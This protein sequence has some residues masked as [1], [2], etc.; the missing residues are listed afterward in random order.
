MASITA[1]LLSFAAIVCLY[2]VMGGN[3]LRLVPG[4]G[5]QK[6]ALSPVPSGFSPPWFCHGIDCPPYRVL[7]SNSSAY[8]IRHYPAVDYATTVVD[9]MDY[10]KGSSTGEEEEEEEEER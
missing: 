5:E 2:G 1:L 3:A 10:E 8:E 6:E 9:G 4:F 7:P